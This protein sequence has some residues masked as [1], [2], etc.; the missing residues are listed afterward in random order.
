MTNTFT[1]N[2]GTQGTF[3]YDL[4]GSADVLSAGFAYVTTNIVE[5]GTSLSFGPF[6]GSSGLHITFV[7]S[8]EQISISGGT[9]NDW[10]VGT[11]GDDNLRGQGGDD[12]LEG[13]EGN[14]TLGG[15][16]GND[17]LFGGAG[18][19][20][21]SGDDGNN[22]LS[23]G[24]G[25]DTLIG[26]NGNNTLD[27]GAGNDQMRGGSGADTY[28]FRSGDGSDTIQDFSPAK[29]DKIDLTGVSEVRNFAELQAHLY[30]TPTYAQ[31]KLSSTLSIAL[32][33]VNVADLTKDAFIFRSDV[34]CFYPGTRIAT[35][36]GCVA[37]Q[38]L[39]PGDLLPCLD[40][41]HRPLL[42]LGRQTV[43]TRG[44]HVD[45][46]LP[47]R[48]KAGALGVGVPSRDLLVS[49]DHAI[50]VDG[51]LVSARALINGR[52]V[53]RELAAPETFTYFHIEFSEHAILFAEDAPAESFVDNVD[54]LHFDNWAEHEA[55]FPAGTAMAE[56]PYPRAKSQRQVPRATRERLRLRAEALERADR[57]WTNAA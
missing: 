49:P 21:L 44:L 55:L 2:S 12:V 1:L 5:S 36:R 14:D 53:L 32:M 25:N 38:D 7:S 15:G 26:G 6:A 52:S 41:V 45:R 29:G 16:P 50:L 56:L 9:G 31:I 20:T 43:S 17:R 23:G 46:I 3:T 22:Y 35:A 47:I 34:S 24:L 11:K 57:Q 27:G 54:R 48:I 13:L 40:G 51:N 30:Q 33:K 39:V 19:D 10:F 37:V 8:F 18:N 4:S 42:W 28:I